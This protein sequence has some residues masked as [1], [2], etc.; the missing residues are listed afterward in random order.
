MRKCDGKSRPAVGSRGDFNHSIMGLNNLPVMASPSP[1]PAGFAGG[2]GGKNRRER[3]G[4]PYR[5]VVGDA[6]N[7][8][9]QIFSGG[10]RHA[11][12]FIRRFKGI[13]QK[14][15]KG[16]FQLHRISEDRRKLG[17]QVKGEMFSLFLYVRLEA[18][19]QREQKLPDVH[20]AHEKAAIIGV[21][22]QI[23]Q[24]LQSDNPHPAWSDP[25]IGNHEPRGA[26]SESTAESCESASAGC[27]FR[28]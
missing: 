28:V 3:L 21:R 27:A 20:L 4:R 7:Q 6:D 17:G 23:L 5:A 14:I 22:A 11:A 15:Q 10:E 25:R 9:I 13:F 26:C 8:L 19:F 2:E 1:V 18:A 24:K 12:A 16:L